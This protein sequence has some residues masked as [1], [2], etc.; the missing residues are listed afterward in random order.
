MGCPQSPRPPHRPLDPNAPVEVA[1]KAAPVVKVVKAVNSEAWKDFDGLN[2][3]LLSGQSLGA[4]R[5]Y[6]ANVLKLKG[7]SLNEFACIL[8]VSKRSSLHMGRPLIHRQSLE[9]MCYLVRA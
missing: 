3:E 8:R 7:M 9:L 5:K 1:P 4:L 6:A 2:N